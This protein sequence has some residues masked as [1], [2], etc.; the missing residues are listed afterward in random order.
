MEFELGTV[1]VKQLG[2]EG[3]TYKLPVPISGFL[4]EVAFRKV[5]M[6]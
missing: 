3:S 4:R 5:T 2:V 1:E 6:W